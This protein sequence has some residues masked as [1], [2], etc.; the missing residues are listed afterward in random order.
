MC[1][2]VIISA[3][4][5]FLIITAGIKQK[6]IVGKNFTG[7]NGFTAEQLLNTMKCHCHLMVDA[8]NKL[9]VIKILIL[10]T[11]KAIF[12][13]ICLKFANMSHQNHLLKLNPSM[14]QKITKYALFYSFLIVNNNVLL[15]PLEHHSLVNM[16]TKVSWS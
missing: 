8:V 5:C 3:V 10:K 7:L 13:R 12:L 11:L 14:F 4:A 15:H 16:R 6:N 1:I 2:I 9:P